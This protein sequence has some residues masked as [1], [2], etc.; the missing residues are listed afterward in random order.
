MKEEAIML[1]LACLIIVT[2]FGATI[3]WFRMRER[4]IRAEAALD[5]VRRA[6]GPSAVSSLDSA[7]QE[8]AVEVERLAEGQRFIARVLSERPGGIAPAIPKALGR[9]DTPH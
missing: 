9:V 7:I 1:A 4:A 2:A 8:M 5:E 3:A 6:N